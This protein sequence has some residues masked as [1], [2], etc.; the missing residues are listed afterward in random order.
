[1]QDDEPDFSAILRALDAS[2]VRYVL[3]GG[4][5]MIAHGSA[6]VTVDMDIMKEAANRPKDRNHLLELR[7]LKKAIDGQG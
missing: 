3:I 6:H 2:K 1:M 4:L 5:A 7:A